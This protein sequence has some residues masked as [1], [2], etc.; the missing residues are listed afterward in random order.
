M[1]FLALVHFRTGPMT[2][3]WRN[4][5]HS[6]TDPVLLL[7][8]HGM[9]AP[10]LRFILSVIGL[11]RNCTSAVFFTRSSI[12]QTKAAQIIFCIDKVKARKRSF[13]ELEVA[14]NSV[15]YK[16]NAIDFA[17][18]FCWNFCRIFILQF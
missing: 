13:T 17:L 8:Y 7:A 9:H 3:A 11:V 10:V 16:E 12:C 4:K 1:V 18:E 14:L 6:H 15:L 2:D 5:A